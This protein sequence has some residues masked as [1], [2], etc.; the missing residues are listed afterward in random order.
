MGAQHVSSQQ[1]T[2]EVR[3]VIIKVCLKKCG[4]V[5]EPLRE[6]LCHFSFPEMK[7]KMCVQEPSCNTMSGFCGGARLY[8]CF[9]LKWK[10][11]IF[12][13]GSHHDY[14]AAVLTKIIIVQERKLQSTF[15]DYGSEK[16]DLWCV[17]V[18][19]LAFE[20]VVGIMRCSNFRRIDESV[21][22]DLK[23][24]LSI[25]VMIKDWSKVRNRG[26]AKNLKDRHYWCI[27]QQAEIAFVWKRNYK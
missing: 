17:K 6:R 12:F 14:H 11:H 27:E 22:L 19:E 15:F 18:K 13:W 16:M 20:I 1:W 7:K 26:F 10:H 24:C 25:I 8:F 3:P 2:W 23:I 5:K 21:K 4:N 9:A